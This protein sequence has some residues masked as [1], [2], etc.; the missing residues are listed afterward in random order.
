MPVREDAEPQAAEAPAES[1]A[2]VAA[3]P[4]G[5]VERVLALQRRAGNRA[6]A[7]M[8]ARAPEWAKEYT[9][10]KTRQGLTLEQYKDKI[11]AAGAESFAPEAKAASGW[12]GRPI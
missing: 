2:R 9:T 8:L 4:V 6:V 5:A 1:V 3:G 10:K 11:G 12:G 7:A